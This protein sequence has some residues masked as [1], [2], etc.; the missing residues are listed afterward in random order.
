MIAAWDSKPLVVR[1]LTF[2]WALITLQYLIYG[3]VLHTLDYDWFG[4]GIGFWACVGQSLI[5]GLFCFGYFKGSYWAW[6]HGSAA[7]F[8]GVIATTYLTSEATKALASF[9][10]LGLISSYDVPIL[11]YQT[12]ATLPLLAASFCGLTS[13]FVLMLVA[14]LMSISRPARV[15]YGVET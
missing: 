12:G 10:R 4:Q 3:W 5:A 7:S 15:A 6:H 2:V 1:Q 9:L 8:L 13:G 14:F 11:Q